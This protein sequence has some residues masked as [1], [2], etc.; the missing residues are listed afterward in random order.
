L[1]YYL[2]YFVLFALLA[3]VAFYV[4]VYM[5]MEPM[6]IHPKY[7]FIPCLL[8]ALL[9][10]FPASLERR[11]RAQQEAMQRNIKETTKRAVAKNSEAS[12]TRSKLKHDKLTGAI[13][14]DSFNEIIGLKIM[15]AK[16]VNSALSLILFDIDHFKKIN[17]TYGHLVGDTILKELADLVRNNLRES[18]YFVRWGGEEFVIL[19]PGTSLQGAQMVAEK[20]RRVVREHDF[21]EVGGVTCS[22]GVTTLKEDDTIKSFIKR[23]DEALYEAKN[24]GRNR[25]KVKI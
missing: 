20:L 13:S 16:H 8:V 9:A 6:P 10:I 5:V 22:F 2:K 19:L 17:D 15:E 25:V 1:K 23:A 3:C 12:L 21:S 18:E 7:F 14:K 11:L 24:E 4:Q